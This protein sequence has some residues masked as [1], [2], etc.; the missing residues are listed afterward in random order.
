[1]S[2]VI[3]QA[4][5]GIRPMTLDDLDEVVRIEQ[6]IYNFPWT[7][8]IFRDCLHVGY[9]CWVLQLDGHVHAYGILSMGAG[10]AHVLTLCVNPALQRRG[11]GQMMLDYLLQVARQHQA[12]SIYL[13]VR[14]SNNGAIA[15]YQRTGFT[16]IGMRPGYYPAEHGR[17]DALVMAMEL[18]PDA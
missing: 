3:K 5:D 1:M 12:Q 14:P 11:Y 13:E 17:E 8:G 16:E 18:L 4:A 9:S 2:A 7:R 15:L 6:S 10:E